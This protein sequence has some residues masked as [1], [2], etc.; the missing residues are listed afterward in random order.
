M[1]VAQAGAVFVDGNLHLHPS[2]I[3]AITRMAQEK[4]KVRLWVPLV[5]SFP[6]GL[7]PRRSLF[8][9]T[10]QKVLPIACWNMGSAPHNV[11]R[12]P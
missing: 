4:L 7:G 12:P 6:G 2:W 8:A 5:R 10:D 11:G 9:R 1:V 3:C